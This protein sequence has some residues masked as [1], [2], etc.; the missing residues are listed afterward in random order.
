MIGDRASFGQACRVSFGLAAFPAVP[1]AT[2]PVEYSRYG[3]EPARES[4]PGAPCAPG[5]VLTNQVSDPRIHV[6]AGVLFDASGRVLVAR[7]PEGGHLAGLWEFP[8]GKLVPDESRKAGLAR[9]LAEEL[10]I[11]ILAAHPLIQVE[12]R[13]P[14]REVVLDVWRVESYS[15]EPHGREGQP[16]AWRDVRSLDSA[17]FP[18]ADV[19]VLAALRLPRR[20][21]VTPEP[22]RSWSAFLERLSARVEQGFELVQLRAKSLREPALLDLGARAADICRRSGA[23]LLVNASPEVARRCGAGGVHLTGERLA[24]MLRER[25]SAAGDGA[26]S[27]A[28]GSEGDRGFLVGASCHDASDIER[29]RIAGC[30]FVV[31]GPVRETA[32]HPGARVLRWR[33]FEPLAR[34]AGMPVYAIGGLGDGD[35]AAAS[36]NGGQGVAAIRAFWGET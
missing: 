30:D 23:T 3:N 1:C 27:P 36:T 26:A 5:A 9:E 35:I 24:R 17:D 16:I 13:Y 10:G 28:S 19:P 33:G 25:P 18:P 32:T 7:R 22:G 20:Y 6:V 21:L 31:L 2:S 12:H 11:L 15:G 8:G 14:D 4:A 34:G 29:A